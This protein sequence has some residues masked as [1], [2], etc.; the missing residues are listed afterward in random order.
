MNQ[1]QKFLVS[2][3]TKNKIRQVELEAHW[4]NAAH[5]FMINRYTG[6]FGGKI[7]QQPVIVVQVG[8]AGR[9]VT[10]QAALQFNSKLKEY[11][12]KGYKEIPQ[13]PDTYTEAELR[14]IVGSVATNQ[15]GV[16]KPM[17]AK[18]ADKVTNQKIYNKPWWASRKIDG[19]RCL[20]YWDGKQVRT[21]SRGGENYD[22][23]TSHLRENEQLIEFF[24]RHPSIILW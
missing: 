10:E 4:D 21:A 16:L 19:V 11:K 17:L 15:A 14:E 8:K 5:A 2:I 1:L 24:E 22:P 13:D 6:M 9:T 18:Q 23:A 20:M 3:D 12:D 7:S